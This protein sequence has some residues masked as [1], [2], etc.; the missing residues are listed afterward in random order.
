M[1]VRTYLWLTA[2]LGADKTFVRI[3]RTQPNLAV[4]LVDAIVQVPA[5]GLQVL[6][7]RQ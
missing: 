3:L 1:S 7:H 5:G 2:N 6:F 4:K